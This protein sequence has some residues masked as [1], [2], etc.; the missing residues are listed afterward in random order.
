MPKP[1]AKAAFFMS[2]NVPKALFFKFFLPIL[3]NGCIVFTIFIK[4][5]YFIYKS[6]LLLIMKINYNNLLIM[7]K[8]ANSVLMYILTVKQF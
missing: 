3:H 6:I 4:I 2:K 8:L 7:I 1:L 5:L